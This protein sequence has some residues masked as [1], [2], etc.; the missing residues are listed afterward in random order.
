MCFVNDF[1]KTNTQIRLTKVL[2]IVK[3]IKNNDV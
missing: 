2:L 3:V 1:N